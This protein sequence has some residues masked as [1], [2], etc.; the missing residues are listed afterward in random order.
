TRYKKIHVLPA[1]ISPGP[2]KPKNSDSYLF[3][4]FHHLSAIQREN[5]N[6]GIH[7]WDF[8]Q[9]K[10]ILSRII[11]LLTEADAL[12]LVEVDGRVGHHGAQG[13]RIGC[14]MKGRHKPSS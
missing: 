11:H 3:R 14:P 8:V 13:C 4:S 5:N 6:A 7:V 1:V 2:H 12:G 10:I 9:N